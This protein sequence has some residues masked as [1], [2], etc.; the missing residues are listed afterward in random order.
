MIVVS[1]C[2]GKKLGRPGQDLSDEENAEVIA[3][4]FARSKSRHQRARDRQRLCSAPRD[5]DAA[6]QM[7]PALSDFLLFSHT[8]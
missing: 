3:A 7:N 8:L 1:E 5:R 6:Q 2:R 4:A